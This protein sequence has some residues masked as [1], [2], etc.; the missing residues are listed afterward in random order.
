MLDSDPS[1]GSEP[2]ALCGRWG[3]ALVLTLAIVVRLTGLLWGGIYF[4][5]AFGRGAKILS[6]QFMPD[7]FW[8]PPLL[9]YLNAVAYAAL[10][11]LGRVLGVWSDTAAFRNQYFENRTPFILTARLVTALLGALAAPLAVL[12]AREGRLPW[13]AALLVGVMMAVMPAGVI[14]SHVVK[15]DIGMTTALLFAIWAFGHKLAHPDSRWADLHFGFASALAVSFKH[16]A[17]FLLAGLWLGMFVSMAVAPG[18]TVVTAMASLV[19]A[20]LSA[21]IAWVPMNFGLLLDMHSFLYFQGMQQK[22]AQ[23]P[24]SVRTFLRFV[25]PEL[26]GTFSGATLS[27]LVAGVAAPLVRRDRV[28]FWVWLATA[29]GLGVVASIIG[30]RVHANLILPFASQFYLLGSLTAVNLLVRPGAMRAVGAM[31]TALILGQ[32]MIGSCVFLRQALSPSNFW[33]ARQAL[34]RIAVRGQTRIMASFPGIRLGLPRSAA[35]EREENRREIRLAAKY[36]ITLPPLPA[37]RIGERSGGT[38]GYHIRGYCWNGGLE[39]IAE[40]EFSEIKPFIWS[41]QHDEWELQGWLDQGYSVFVVENE[42]WALTTVPEF[43]RRFFEDVRRRGRLVAYVP[44]RRPLLWEPT[45]RIYQID[46]VATDPNGHHEQPGGNVGSAL[47]PQPAKAAGRKDNP[48]HAQDGVRLL[49]QCVS[50]APCPQLRV[51][52]TGGAAGPLSD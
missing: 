23:H 29:L 13:R 48:W 10:Y 36:G 22:I 41:L 30:S 31:A 34:E 7:Q 44:N 2:R 50:T 21:A 37:E 35:V 20:G 17:L 19:R 8:Y 15:S 39:N 33:Y 32:A 4:D 49:S 12:I 28:T 6:G 45:I 14:Q 24:S 46:P 43:V 1:D 27:A 3:L 51:E 18:R 9:D 25:L 42:P 38:A 5:E 47:G 11:G 16:T 52:V 26:A 40:D